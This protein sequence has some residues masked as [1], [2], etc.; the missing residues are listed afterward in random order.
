MRHA[1]RNEERIIDSI[2]ALM[3]SWL[4]ASM[5]KEGPH[6]RMIRG[7]MR[8]LT[9]SR[10]LEELSTTDALTGLYNR[11]FFQSYLVNRVRNIR[12]GEKANLSLLFFDIDN[13]KKYNDAF[14]HLEGDYVLKKVADAIKAALRVEDV[15]TRYGGEEFTV[16]LICDAPLAFSIAERVRRTI[17]DSCSAF[18]DHRIKA[19]IT[20]SIGL[21]TFGLDADSGERLV[22]VADRRMYE[23]KRLGKNQVYAGPV[24]ARS[25]C[26]RGASSGDEHG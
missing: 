20:V 11:G 13:F 9:R 2:I 15:A 3:G 7:I 19:G 18:A 10:E 1:S 17:E 24:T 6:D 5:E 4:N 16:I 12:A 21:A 25:S 14:G 22:N 23:A 26:S 8:D